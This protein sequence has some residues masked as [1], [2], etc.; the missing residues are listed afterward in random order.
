LGFKNLLKKW[1]MRVSAVFLPVSIGLIVVAITLLMLGDLH[2]P[3]FCLT[4]LS[5]AFCALLWY[6]GVNLGNRA[7]FFF[8]ATFLF[9]T[10]I[11]TFVIDIGLV[12]VSF[13]AVWPFLM[14][15]VGVSFF[16]SGAIRY[17]RLHS[18]YIAPGLAFLGLGILFL[19]FS[20]H[21][22]PLSLS[23]AVLWGFPVFLLPLGVAF[24][25]WF[26]RK[27]SHGKDVDA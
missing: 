12:T 2:L 17:R 15:F 1:I 10:G 20:F 23:T 24:I 16:V 22:I 6:S 3:R 19:L 7:R 25:I 27:I 8:A 9:L 14:M 18:M 11:L 13:S 5:F 21:L 26:V 4:I